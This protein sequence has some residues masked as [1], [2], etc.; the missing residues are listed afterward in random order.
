[1]IGICKKDYVKA[2]VRNKLQQEIDKNVQ[3]YLDEVSGLKTDIEKEIAIHNKMLE[4]VTYAEKTDI[5]VYFTLLFSF[6]YSSSIVS[7]LASSHV[8]ST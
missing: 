3:R 1:M 7:Y 8:T 4:E 2:D 5:Q 6:L